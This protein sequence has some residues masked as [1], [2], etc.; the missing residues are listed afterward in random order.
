[1]ERV[2]SQG[3][4]EAGDDA[5]ENGIGFGDGFGWTGWEEGW[6]REVVIAG[7]GGLAVVEYEG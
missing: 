4:D 1:M 2:D 5:L 3:A 6:L 7:E